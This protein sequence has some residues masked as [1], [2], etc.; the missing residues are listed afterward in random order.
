[1]FKEEVKAV[2][3]SYVAYAARGQVILKK[4]I[5]VQLGIGPNGILYGA[6][7]P[8]ECSL[9]LSPIPPCHWQN[10][11]KVIVHTPYLPGSLAEV[12]KAIAQ[13]GLNTI[14]GWASTESSFGH[15]AATS[16]VVPDDCIVGGSLSPQI[17]EQKLNAALEHK[18]TNLPQ[19]DRRLS[20]IRVTPLAILA[21]YGAILTEKKAEFIATR[22]DQHTLCLT[23]AYTQS[24]SQPRPSLWSRLVEAADAGDTSA[25]IL[26]PDTEEAFLRVVAVSQKTRLIA[27]SFPI[28]IRS[29]DESF[30]GYWDHAVNLISERNLSIFSAHNLIIRKSE[31]PPIE[32]AEFHFL[33]DRSR[34]RD[35]SDTLDVIAR[36]LTKE[37]RGSFEE[38]GNQQGDE[39]T[40]GDVRVHRPRGVGVL[41]FFASNADRGDIQGLKVAIQLCRILE[42]LGFR[43]VN[44]DLAQGG[45]FLIREVK[46]LLRW[47][48]FMV[49]LHC[50]PEKLKFASGEVGL[51][52]WVL[53]EEWTMMRKQ[54][55][56]NDVSIIRLRFDGVVESGPDRG[57]VDIII[58]SEGMPVDEV[59]NFVKRV[60]YWARQAAI[61]DEGSMVAPEIPDKVWN[62]DLL[63]YYENLYRLTLLDIGKGA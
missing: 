35:S 9:I 23:D 22:V 43:P 1:L 12:A 63:S 2:L 61:L 29:S 41:C 59:D 16:I 58:P 21:A 3:R 56:S 38:K 15:L 8:E 28:T 44:V 11:L 33:L 20:S 52:P 39:V 7:F 60:E 37:F 27:L 42:G 13:L 4:E 25:C 14:S 47:C 10:A 17:I 50:C 5:L 40:I 55:R 24:R 34:S 48:R 18:L 32:E 46:D 36:V 6:F 30:I 45:D 31:E 54:G 57:L 49:V 53:F 51:S 19:F 26:T 62:R